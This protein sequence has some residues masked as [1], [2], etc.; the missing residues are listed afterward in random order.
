MLDAEGRP[1][2]GLTEVTDLG[3]ADAPPGPVPPGGRRPATPLVDVIG[4]LLSLPQRGPDSDALLGLLLCQEGRESE[5]L[6]HLR[7][8]CD[9]APDRPG[10]RA[11]LA[12]ATLDAGYLPATWR[13]TARARWPKPW[14][15]PSPSGPD[16]A[17]YLCGVMADED[18]EEESIGQLNALSEALPGAGPDAPGPGRRLQEAGHGRGRRG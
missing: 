6:A 14:S 9:A 18:R 8:A 17:L 1:W 15:R 16:M 10:L 13:R 5:G 12:R 4:F 7:A 3:R 11:L 2:A